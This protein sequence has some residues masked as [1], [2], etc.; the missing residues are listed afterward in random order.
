MKLYHID[1]ALGIKD[2]RPIAQ[3]GEVFRQ[4]MT[5]NDSKTVRVGVVEFKDGAHTKMHAH[6]GDQ[7]LVIL[8]GEGLYK[9]ETEEYHVKKGDVML[10]YAGE[11]HSHGAEPGKSVTQL[12]IRAVTDGNGAN[13]QLS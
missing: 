4:P 7:I 9:T 1:P 3:G 12:G 5:D 2:E 6:D 13:T 11:I 8:D 10:F